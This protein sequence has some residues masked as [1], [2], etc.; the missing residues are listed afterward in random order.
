MPVS[1]QADFLNAASGLGGKVVEGVILKSA[2]GGLVWVYIFAERM[3][4]RF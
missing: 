1:A 3:P 2:G 4:F